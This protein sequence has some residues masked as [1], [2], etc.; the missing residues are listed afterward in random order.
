VEAR[1]GRLHRR[2]RLG[3]GGGA[4]RDGQPSAAFFEQLVDDVG[5]PA[6]EQRCAGAVVIDSI[7]ALPQVLA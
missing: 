1:C 6:A 2:D 3:G 4:D 7:A 5:V